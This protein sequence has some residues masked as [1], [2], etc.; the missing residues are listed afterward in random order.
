MFNV[1]GA[2]ICTMIGAYCLYFESDRTFVRWER[3]TIFIVRLAEHLLCESGRTFVL[4]E[5]Q[6][7]YFLKVFF[8]ALT[9]FL[10]KSLCKQ[11]GPKPTIK[12][13]KNYPKKVKRWWIGPSC[14]QKTK[15]C[16]ISEQISALGERSWRTLVL[17]ELQSI[18]T[19]RVA[20]CLY[21][22]SSRTF[23]WCE[24]TFLLWWWQNICIVRLTDHFCCESG[25]TF[26]L[27]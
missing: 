15:T 19:V 21:F 8:V 6:N 13:L 22:E 18:W 9:I 25:R 20:Y 4:W 5:W 16:A 14:V 3:Q 1:R 24:G 2:E 26:V 7:I 12:K 11:N 17:W 23:V 10:F 27:W